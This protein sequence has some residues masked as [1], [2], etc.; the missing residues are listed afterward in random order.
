MPRQRRNGGAASA[1]WATLLI[2]NAPK[3]IGLYIAVQEAH[4]PN[5]RDSIIAFCALC[6]VGAQVAENVLLRAVDRFFD[7]GDEHDAAGPSEDE[8]GG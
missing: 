3:L 2:T 6:I 1:P 4:R 5:A 7:G 8:E